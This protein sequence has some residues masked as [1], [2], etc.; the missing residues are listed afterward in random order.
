M[1]LVFAL[2]TPGVSTPEVPKAGCSYGNP[3]TR[4]EQGPKKVLELSLHSSI[5]MQPMAFLPTASFIILYYQCVFAKDRGE[6]YYLTQSKN[7][8]K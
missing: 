3:H 1:V 5:Y 4:N 6:Y 8:W 2:C 7:I